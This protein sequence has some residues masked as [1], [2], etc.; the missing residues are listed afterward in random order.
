[1][2]KLTTGQAAQAL[3]TS[4]DTIRRL[5]RTGHLKAEKFTNSAQFRIREDVLRDYAEQQGVTLTLDAQPEK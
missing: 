1:M 4:R 5:I 2:R 3:H